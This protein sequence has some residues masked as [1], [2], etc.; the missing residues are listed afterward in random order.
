MSL[1][2]KKIEEIG[3]SVRS[4]NGLHKA[5]IKTVEDL[6]K[7]DEERLYRIRKLGR[8]SVDEILAKI[9]EL[10]ALSKEDLFDETEMEAEA[11]APNLF[12]CLSAR[13]YNL[14]TTSGYADLERV[15]NITLEE[16]LAI[17][18]MDRV[19]AESIIKERDKYIAKTDSFSSTDTH[20]D[21]T[22]LM[23]NPFY[24]DRIMSYVQVNDISIEDLG[25]NVRSYNCLNNSGYKK[26]SEI[27]FL[28]D[29]DLVKIKNMGSGS[30]K[31]IRARINEYLSKHGDRISSFCSEK[32]DLIVDDALIR[33][34]ILGIYRE[35]GFSGASFNDLLE[36]S[37][38]PKQID[39]NR[40]KR[41]IGGLIAEG[42]LEYVDYRC[43][44]VYDRFA[45][46][47]T[48]S[49]TISDRNKRL[50]QRK[51]NDET[52]ESIGQ[53]LGVTR[54]RVRQIINKTVKAVLDEHAAKSG[55]R[56]FDEDYYRY[57]YETYEFDRKDG[58]DWFGIQS[59]VWKYLDLMD[60]K[61]GKKDL[62]DALSDQKIDVA[63]RIKIR[64]Y[65][66]RNKVFV[67]GQWV[68]K[69]RSALESV[70]ARILCKNEIS[71]ED[72]VIKYNNYL[73]M[74]GIPYDEDL[75]VTEQIKRS[76]RNRMA[77]AD[78][79]LWK[80]NEM[81][82]YYDI[83]GRDY[84]EL[85]DEL[86]LDSYNNIEISTAKLMREH[87]QLMEKYDIRDQYELHNLLR[88]I[89]PIGRYK[90]LKIGRMPDLCF[91]NFDLK[92]SLYELIKDNSPIKSTDLIDLIVDEFGYDRGTIQGSYLPLLNMYYHN[93]EYSIDH[94]NISDNY[95]KLLQRSLTEDFYYI[96]EIRS[97]YTEL[98]PGANPDDIDWYNLKRMGFIVLARYAIQHYSSLEA[99]FTDLLTS[100]E[101][102][103]INVLRKRFL[104]VSAFSGTLTRLKKER[105]I[106]ELE[107]NQLITMK[108][109]NKAGISDEDLQ[110]FCDMVYNWVDED[111]YF[112]IS[113][114]KDGGFDPQIFELGFS[115]WF[116]ASVV[117]SDS[118]F[119]FGN[120][121]S[122]I[123]LIKGNRD[124]L[125]K[126][127]IV[128][129]VK[130]HG[131]V[132]E[133][134]LL[135]EVND[136]YGCKVTDKSDLHYKTSNSDIYYDKVLDRFYA[137]RKLY[138]EELDLAEE[139]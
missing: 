57:L 22:V 128:S 69:K 68:E 137:S 52:L 38:L 105:V 60:V 81:M 40:I 87:P 107:P 41:I 70:L 117:A 106:F 31:L 47:L 54:E 126:D 32:G 62:N 130:E 44:K 124:M 82:R 39:I 34:R 92:T 46:A 63:L 136:K 19:T 129:L 108:K 80:M 12:A 85:F 2:E 125:T 35:L 118:R 5:E 4:Y 66:N 119:S 98:I 30:V 111:R 123:V 43:Y 84:T 27:V 72:F 56:L 90:D 64:N 36:K 89:I 86:A 28:H 122:N 100:N 24:H 104:Y 134:D 61:R 71:F 110:E 96:D 53:D 103:D 26:L 112:T 29:E 97:K 17:P 9:A 37:Q 8:K 73:Q 109:L 3:L 48:I 51:L 76:R 14:L 15:L 78:F 83:N 23:N 10:K 74:E 93:G 7:L 21:I 120:M 13:A 88:K 11:D 65:L 127:F 102:T 139:L 133:Y 55:T 45:D 94:K 1:L 99:Y 33:E 25:L 59:Y 132:D 138:D 18:F 6:L 113:S 95:L 67:A 20:E 135:S 42:K 58:S 116:Y 91:G 77:D 16:L 121:F 131:S 101:I 115:D 75:Y 49:E 114:L 79:I 50:V